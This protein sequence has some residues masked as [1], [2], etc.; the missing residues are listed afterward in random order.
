MSDFNKVGCVAEF[1]SETENAR[2]SGDRMWCCVV[3][4]HLCACMQRVL[5]VNPGPQPRY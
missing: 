4:V 1:E 3:C 2:E 5:S